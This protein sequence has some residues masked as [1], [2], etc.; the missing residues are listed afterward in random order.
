MILTIKAQPE[1]FTTRELEEIERRWSEGIPSQEVISLFQARGVKLSE[2]TF[3]KYIQ[4]GLLPTSRRVG[5]KGKHRG[6]RGLYPVSV[7]RRINVIKRMMAEDLTLEEIRDSFFSV[8]NQL[9]K[10]G[11]AMDGLIASLRDHIERLRERGEPTTDVARELKEA[12]KSSKSLLK[13]IE[14]IQSRLAIIGS[15][16]TPKD[17]GGL[18]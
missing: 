6:S 11:E 18:P 10:A 12:Q 9:E 8:Q 1:L 14:R 4:L 3:R 2:A 7:V 16:P 15:R 17:Q 13:K 5:R